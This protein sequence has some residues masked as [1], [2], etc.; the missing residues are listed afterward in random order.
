MNLH[1]RW[2]ENNVRI[3]RIGELIQYLFF[4]L[5]SDHFMCILGAGRAMSVPNINMCRVKKII[6]FWRISIM[7]V[8]N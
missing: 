1:H 4:H 5:T 2:V 8:F 7:M 6:Y 3:Y